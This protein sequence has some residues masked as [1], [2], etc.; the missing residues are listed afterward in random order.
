MN[1]KVHICACNGGRGARGCLRSED[2]GRREGGRDGGRE[3]ERAG[4]MAGMN[5]GGTW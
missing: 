5:G 4:G 3:G 2:V 1:N